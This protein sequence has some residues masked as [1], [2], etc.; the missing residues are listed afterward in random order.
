M[1]TLQPLLPQGAELIRPPTRTK[2]F[3]SLSLAFG[4][5][6]LPWLEDIR[7]LVPDFTLMALLYWNIHAPRLT[8]LGAAFVFGLLTDV[9]RGVF[10]GLNALVYCAATFVALLVHR[11]L[12]GFSIPHQALQISPILLGKELLLLTLGLALGRGTVD[13][14]WLAAGLVA[15]LLWPPMA[16]LFD[17]AT[18]RTRSSATAMQQTSR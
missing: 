13:W 5:T 6:L 9:A 1:N 8:G 10:F 18:G 17:R 15:V 2:V 11:R 14:R 4:V 3:G 12:E 7:W 16:W